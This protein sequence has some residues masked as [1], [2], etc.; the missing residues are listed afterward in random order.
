MNRLR[1]LDNVLSLLRFRLPSPQR[2][3]P[4]IAG[5]AQ[6]SDTVVHEAAHST[7]DN[8]RH[9]PQGKEDDA[10]ANRAIQ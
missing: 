4:H 7:D 10:Y 3:E 8:D 5:A 1:V 6:M 9:A 2:R